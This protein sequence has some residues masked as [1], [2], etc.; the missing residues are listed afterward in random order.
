MFIAW[1]KAISTGGMLNSYV[2]ALPRRQPLLLKQQQRILATSHENRMIRR[3]DFQM[4]ALAS[5]RCL[6]D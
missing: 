5:Q 2:G 4:K 6:I 1:A 3:S